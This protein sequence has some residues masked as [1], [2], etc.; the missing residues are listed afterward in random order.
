MMLAR[1]FMGAILGY[2]ALYGGLWMAV[3][4]HML[5]NLI[6]LCQMYLTGDTAMLVIV[7]GWLF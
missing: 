3:L 1:W 5:N 2:I 4:L 7:G 6:V